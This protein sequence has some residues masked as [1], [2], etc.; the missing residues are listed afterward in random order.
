MKTFRVCYGDRTGV[1]IRC[2]KIKAAS[3]V[4]AARI[5]LRDDPNRYVKVGRSV[6]Y[7][8]DRGKVVRSNVT[9]L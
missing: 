9:R 5:C 2:R 7:K 8:N 1:R 3:K 4:E 6:Y